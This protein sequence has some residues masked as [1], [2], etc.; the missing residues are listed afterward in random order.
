MKRLS[1]FPAELALAGALLAACGCAGLRVS[2]ELRAWP[3]AEMAVPP[4]SNASAADSA[5]DAVRRAAAGLMEK[6]GY[7]PL[8]YDDGKPAPAAGLVCRGD[9]RDFTFEAEG[10]V[11]RK[12]VRIKVRIV[13]ASDGAVLYAGSGSGS[14]SKV[15]PDAAAARTAL[16]EQG[17][18]REPE[19]A[20]SR[21]ISDAVW[22]ALGALPRRVK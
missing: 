20:L 14:S 2:P 16:A 12:S 9:V 8:P 17:G 1:P 19:A 3:S 21:E 11:L 10:P 6:M 4:F 7:A 22:E 18:G 15:Y 13:R 5:P